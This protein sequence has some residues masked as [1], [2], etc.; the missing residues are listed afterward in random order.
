MKQFYSGSE[1]EG[2]VHINSGIINHLFYQVCKLVC[3]PNDTTWNKPLKLW[4]KLLS[5]KHITTKCTFQDFAK[6]LIAAAEPAHVDHVRK[7]LTSVGL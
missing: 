7:A 2:G 5:E 1:D 3:G 6:A 4:Y